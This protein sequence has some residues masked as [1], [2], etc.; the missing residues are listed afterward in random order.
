[1]IGDLV[2][3]EIAVMRFERAPLGANKFEAHQKIVAA[4][5]I[6]TIAHIDQDYQAAYNLFV[7]L[8][9]RFYST[10]D[11]QA[12]IGAVNFHRAMEL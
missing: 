8:R 6:P 11:Q 7:E 9:E 3:I 4:E 12:R 2:L 5:Y 10:I 1:M